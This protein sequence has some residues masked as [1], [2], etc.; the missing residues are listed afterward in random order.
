MAAIKVNIDCWDYIE[1][2]GRIC[3]TNDNLSI[4]EY[5]EI[6]YWSTPQDCY[7]IDLKVLDKIPLTGN[8]KKWIYELIN[9]NKII[10]K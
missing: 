7:T 6:Q 8:S 9:P 10:I 5:V 2:N 4:G 3:T 1:K